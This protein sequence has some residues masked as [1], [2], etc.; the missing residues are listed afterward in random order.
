MRRKYPRI[1]KYTCKRVPNSDRDGTKNY[2]KPCCVCGISTIGEWYVEY[3]E[4]RGD[5]ET[6]RV[7]A[8][9]WNMNHDELL[10]AFLNS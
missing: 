3:N 7:C 6:A 1:N 4:M 8:K 9:H 5:D 2:G 10:V